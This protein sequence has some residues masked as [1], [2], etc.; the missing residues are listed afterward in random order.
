MGLI[1]LL[2]PER[3]GTIPK[4][5][6]E[7]ARRPLIFLIGDDDYAGTGPDGWASARRMR[8]WGRRA[9]VHAAEGKPEHYALAVTGA[10]ACGRLVLV[11]CSTAHERAWGAFLAP[12]MPVLDISAPAGLP[13][14]I[15][16]RRGETH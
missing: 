4:R 11:E 16:P 13:H 5:M 2:Q 15:A 7:N 3:P 8:Q 1:N 6:V 10:L 14:P 9:I 12:Y